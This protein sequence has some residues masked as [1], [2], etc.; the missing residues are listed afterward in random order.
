MSLSDEDLLEI[1]PPEL[2]QNNRQPDPIFDTDEFLYIRFDAVDREGR[3][4]FSSL[5]YPNQSSNRSKY[6]SD[7]EWVLLPD[8]ENWGYGRARTNSI[9]PSFT[10]NSG[11]VT[12]KLQVEHD[13]EI[14]NYSHT[15]LRSYSNGQ[16]VRNVK[17]A[18]PISSEFRM[19]MTHLIEI[20]KNPE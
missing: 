11:A 14:Y 19:K 20:M 2:H 3:V 4:S 16:P 9:P 15:E 17:P 8:F 6:C 7:P 1:F 10:T 13:P 5:R 12:H 18:K